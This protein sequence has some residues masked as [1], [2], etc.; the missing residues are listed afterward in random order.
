MKRYPHTLSMWLAVFG[1]A[2]FVSERRWLHL[3]GVIALYLVGVGGIGMAYGHHCAT[4]GIPV[5]PVPF[6]KDLLA[7]GAR[8]TLFSMAR[9]AGFAAFVIVDEIRHHLTRYGII[10]TT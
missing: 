3:T 9:H 4:K 2:C 6:V 5:E 1:T 8:P 7:G 10:E